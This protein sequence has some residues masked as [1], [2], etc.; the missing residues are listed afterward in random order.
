MNFILKE[1]IDYII[2]E[3]EMTGEILA[4]ITC[5]DIISAKGYIIRIKQKK[6]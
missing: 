3:H 4:E 1:D 5:E 2:V 6:L